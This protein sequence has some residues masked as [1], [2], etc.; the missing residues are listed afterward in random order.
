MKIIAIER[1]GDFDMP[2]S[3]LYK[4]SESSPDSVTVL[5]KLKAVNYCASSVSEQKK[6]YKEMKAILRFHGYTKFNPSTV[7][8]SD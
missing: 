7:T 6:I 2:Y 5:G 1:Y 8:I 4:G 3:E